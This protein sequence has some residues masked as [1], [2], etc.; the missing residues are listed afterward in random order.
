[1]HSQKL[2]LLS[3][4]SWCAGKNSSRGG[5]GHEHGHLCDV[6]SSIFSHLFDCAGKVEGGDN[7]VTEVSSIDITVNCSVMRRDKGGGGLQGERESDKVVTGRV[8]VPQNHVK[9]R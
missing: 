8:R 4:I 3:I 2:Y 7:R 5:D 6:I 9:A 1:M